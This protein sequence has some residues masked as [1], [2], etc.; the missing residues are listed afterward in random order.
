MYGDSLIVSGS[1][2]ING[3]LS[4]SSLTGS[5]DYNNLTNVPTLVSGSSQIDITNTT[6]YTTFSSSISSS[7]GELSS[8]IATTDLNQNNRIDSLEGVSGSYATTGSNLFKG[9]QTHS[10]SIVPSVDNLYDLG[11][12]THQWRDVYISSGSLYIDGTKVI[13]STSQ[14]LTITTDNGQ[15]LKILEG[16]TDSIVLQVADGDIE[17]K[18]SGDGDILL[19]PTNG[20]IMLKGP[21]EVLSG[22]KIQSSVGG[23]PVVFA[24]D[25][26]VSGSIDITGTIEGI[27]LTDFSSSVS[28]KLTSLEGM[29]GSLSSFTSSASS[30]LTSIET[31]TSS[32]NSFTSSATSRLTS[33]ESSTSSLN[34]F[35]SS[36]SGRLT[37][38]EN[39]TGSYATTGSNI[40]QGNQTITGSL[41]VSQDLIIAGSS[42][43]QH[44]SSS[45]VNIADNIITVNAQNP[46]IRF[47][48]LA[49]VDSGSFPQV[50]GSILFDSVENQWVFVHQNQLNVT[51]SMV[52]M[53]PETYNSLGNE[54]HLTNNRLVKSVNDEHIGDSNISDSGT[55][56]SINSNTN[57]TGSLLVTN[58]IVSQTT[59]LV[60]GSGQISFSGITGVPSGLVSGSSQV[61]LSSGIWSGSAQLPSGIVSGAA[62]LPSGIISGSSQL[63]SGLVSGSSQVDLTAT[64]N[65]STG[66]KT[67]LNAEGVISGSSQVLSGTGIWSGSAQLPL[68]VISG[69]AQLPSG[70]VSGSS[71]VLNGTTIHSGSFFNGISVVSGSS[72][73]TFGSISSV[74]SGLVSGS[75]QITFGLISSIPSGLVS[76]SSQVLGGTG[77]WS[78]SAQLPNGVVSG[79]SQVTLSSTTGFGTYLNQAVLTTST[80]TFSTVSATTFT[81]ALSGNATT[82]SSSPTLTASGTLTTQAGSGTLIHSS[83][84]VS[85]E[86][87]LFSTSDNS[88]SI[89]TFNRHPGAYYSQLGFNSTGTI[90]YRSFNNTSINTSQAWK[91]IIDSGNIGSQS[92]SSATTATFATNSS[93]LYSTD[94]SYNYTSANPY[95]GYLTYD[96]SRWLFQVSPSSPAAVRVAYADAAGSAGNATTAGGFTPSQTSG[97]ANRIVV[98]DANGYIINNYFNASGGGSERNASG[99]G[100]FA[101]HNTGDYYYRSYT[102]AAAAA[103]L[104]GQ[105]MNINGNAS[106]VTNGVYTN[107]TN[108][109]VNGDSAAIVT[110]GAGSYS[111]AAALYLGG[112]T[113]D[114]TYARIRTSNGNLHIDTRGGA[115]NLYQ[116]YFNHYSSG[117]MYFGNGGG[118]V[119]IY[120]GRLKHSDGTS[121]VY[122]SGT[123]GIG[124]SGN[125]ATSTTSINLIGTGGSVIQSTSTGTSYQYNYQVRENSGGGGNTNE[126]YA[127]Q[128]A[129]H[130]SGVVASSIMMESSGRIAIRNNPGGSYESF[131]AA[132]ITST[133]TLTETSSIRYKKDIETISYGLDKVLQMRGVTY[134]KK[135]NDIKEVG[136]IAEEIAEIFPELVN[137]DTEGRPDSVSYGRITGLLIEAIKDL[138]KEINDLKNNG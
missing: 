9:T 13:S 15:S 100:Y 58:T 98:A 56:V 37:T 127:P 135:E 94:S 110:Y 88:N 12:V 4:G 78:G 74:P 47:G 57:I 108:T 114:T 76:G 27:N 49:V 33:V 3:H 2:K 66:I 54:T 51:S 91:T 123:W 67:R 102:A 70:V 85:S 124:I 10:G 133:G 82:A 31:S 22:Q 40:F 130:W 18:S 72:Q 8:S 41:Y 106:T 44:I 5:I 138:K 50:S 60:S 42:S 20:K 107:T 113:T 121:Y 59:P 90:F 116:M 87:G 46:S 71:Q 81:G 75:S 86:A 68:G 126:I 38:L 24:N 96:G 118:T 26:V 109:I 84:I 48:G 111:A 132:N 64:T 11:S 32:L 80:P 52:I 1:V 63:P 77:I 45:I 53:G 134:L 128:L 43:I 129:F 93:K 35:T 97:T 61:L 117:D 83:P 79:S 14:E 103:L 119:F 29:T 99:M 36:A 125:A 21:V 39:K 28:G 101:G 131:I 105:S 115:G 120:G 104:S 73:I 19:D 7:V 30:R 137:Y 65:Y 92:V 55:N 6:N 23:T 17:L 16:T 62:Q 95:Y 112:W 69:S 34:T 136:V 25:I 122:N 89:I